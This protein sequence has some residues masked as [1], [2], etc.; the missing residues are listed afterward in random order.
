MSRCDC[1]FEE[2]FLVVPVM[3]ADPTSP[4]EHDLVCPACA[5]VLA[6]VHPALYHMP[7]FTLR[8]KQLTTASMGAVFSSDMQ[9][10]V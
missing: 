5:D 6:S 2:S 4:Y 8:H 9:L 7:V 3:N 10:V 1:C